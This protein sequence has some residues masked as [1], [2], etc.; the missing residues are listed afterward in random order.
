MGP[1]ETA[2]LSPALTGVCR[3]RHT[4][5][6]GRNTFGYSLASQASGLQDELMRAAQD[7][8]ELADD[9]LR[10][11]VEIRYPELMPQNKD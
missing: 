1:D 9:L 6:S 5:V 10:G 8:E 11:A 7:F 4:T 2:G 3:T